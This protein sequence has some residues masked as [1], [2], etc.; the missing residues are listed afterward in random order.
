MFWGTPMT[1][2]HRVPNR[3]A[4]GVAAAALAVATIEFRIYAY[5]FRGS[6]NHVVDWV[7]VIAAVIAAA[8][9]GGLAGY[10]LGSMR[11]QQIIIQQLAAK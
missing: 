3:L 5:D 11:P 7:Q 1:W 8:A 10:K 9:I 4:I 2:F 6:Q